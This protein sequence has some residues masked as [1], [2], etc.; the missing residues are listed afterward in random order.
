MG[1][2]ANESLSNHKPLGLRDPQVDPHMD[3]A[4]AE[5]W[6]SVLCVQALQEGLVG[7]LLEYGEFLTRK[8]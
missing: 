1:E 3:S 4:V 2:T 5:I 7:L 8:S 6:G